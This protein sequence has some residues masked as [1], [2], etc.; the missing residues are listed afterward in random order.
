VLRCAE[1]LL[2]ALRCAVVVVRAGDGRLLGWGGVHSVAIVRAWPGLR[3]RVVRSAGGRELLY[4]CMGPCGG[5]FDPAAGGACCRHHDHE[6]LLQ[7]RRQ[8]TAGRCTMPVR[9]KH[10]LC[11]GKR[12]THVQL[13]QRGWRTYQRAA[14]LW[15]IEATRR[16][17]GSRRLNVYKR[18]LDAHRRCT[19]QNACAG[20]EGSGSTCG[21]QECKSALLTC[22]RSF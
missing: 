2:Q 15:R 7:M 17:A 3:G 9:Q 13:R 10:A 20:V 18:H 19:V 1:G 6:T 11:L 12:L 8:H 21:T 5:G 4:G 14:A 22:S 16:G